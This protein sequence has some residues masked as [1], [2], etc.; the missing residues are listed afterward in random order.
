MQEYQ[1]V[2]I[3]AG[4]YGLA[5]AAHLRT[6]AGFEARIFGEPM[7]FWEQHMPE[8]MFLRSQWE[9]SHIADPKG[10]L[11]LNDF[12]ADTGRSISTPV[13]LTDFIA[14]GRWFQ[15]RAVSEVDS[16]QVTAVESTSHGFQV[17]TEDGDAISTRRVVVAAGIAPFAW[18]PPEFANLPP[19]VASHSGDHRDLKRFAGRQVLVVGGG[20]SA[21]ESA[22]L[23]DECGA[24]A[25]AIVRRPVVHWLRW[26]SQFA[27]FQPLSR[28]LY[29]FTDVGPA[30]LSQL[31]ARPHLLRPIPR[32]IQRWIGKRCI[33]PAG[34][35][36]LRDRLRKVPIRTGIHIKRA[37]L[38]GRQLKVGLNDGSERTVD[39]LL[40]ATGYR[41]DIAKYPFLGRPLLSRV[42]QADG[43]PRLKANFES[44]VPGLHFLGA[45]A[46]W[47]FGPLLRFVSG[48]H[49]SVRVLTRALANSA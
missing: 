11:S 7:S 4:P 27:R 36:W 47:S 37:E 31:V 26:K 42:D 44:S 6:I 15:K 8:G 14:Y 21:L 35:A 39:H 30:G 19:D 40:F 34:A 9:A 17:K 32:P 5:A 3:G 41:I 49:Y 12:M 24:A 33:R 22:A 43:Y 16:R 18:R 45:P 13:P 25:E 28:L 10:Q 1:V 29:S 38:V 46:A 2:I 23:L 20:Q 48:A